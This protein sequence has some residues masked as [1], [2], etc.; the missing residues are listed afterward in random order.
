M[1]TPIVRAESQVD[2]ALIGPFPHPP[3]SDGPAD[4]LAPINAL[5]RTERPVNRLSTEA[6]EELFN[7][8]V[9][10]RRLVEVSIVTGCS[11]YNTRAWLSR[12]KNTGSASSAAY[13]VPE[14]SLACR[15][16]DAWA[17]GEWE[18]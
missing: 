5:S 7:L 6:V 14:T 13:T 2:E 17:D 10:R 4:P 1:A 16:L 3:V 9:Q 15:E 11:A 18:K 12:C 8:M